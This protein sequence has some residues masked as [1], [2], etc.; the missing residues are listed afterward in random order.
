MSV[1]VRAVDLDTE[2]EELL[3]VLERNLTDLPH[4]RRFKW[5]Y[6][7]N[8]LGPA[9][10]WFACA[11]ATG[12]VVGVASVF[13]RAMWLGRR[14]MVCGQVGD[15]AIDAGHRSLGPA[16]MLQR[17]TFEPVDRGSLTLCYDCPPHDRG[18]STFRRIGMEASASLAR[19]AKLLRANRKIEGRIGEGAVARALAPVGNALIWLRDGDVPRPNGLEI[20]ERVR[21]RD[22]I[23]GRRSAEDLNWRYR[24]NPLH[25]FGTLAARRRGE[26]IGFVILSGAGR[27]ATL[28]DLFGDFHP[29]DALGLLDAAADEARVAGAETLHATVSDDSHLVVDLGRAG[30]SRRE[31]GPHVVAYT[32]PGSEDR[33][34]LDRPLTWDLT[35]QDIMA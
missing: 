9:W 24:D 32:A 26:L 7:D 23:R 21:S 17:A 4:A 11:G 1:T 5:I 28:V 18:M 13:R 6:R 19:H 25:E 2:H 3:A 27:D 30:F 14:M 20:D 33:A 12:R 10:S 15:F 34:Q 31:A 35:H 8:P 16:V 22:V 29:G